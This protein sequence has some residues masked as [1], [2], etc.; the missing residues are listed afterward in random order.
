[1]QVLGACVSPAD[2]LLY[3]HVESDHTKTQLFCN[4]KV[5]YLVQTTD[6][7]MYRTSGSLGEKAPQM[8]HYV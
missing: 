4:L 8:V 7:A 3:R 5:A 1:M 6:S 2:L